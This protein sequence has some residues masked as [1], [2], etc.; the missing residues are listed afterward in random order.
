[1]FKFIW[2]YLQIWDWWIDWSLLLD[3]GDCS[4]GWFWDLELGELWKD[5]LE[6]RSCDAE[7]FVMETFL[8]L[9]KLVEQI[10]EAADLLWVHIDFD[11]ISN[12]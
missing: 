4:L 9:D 6:G 8:T 2:N 5:L 10:G 11:L 12:V 1:M 3:V 7:V